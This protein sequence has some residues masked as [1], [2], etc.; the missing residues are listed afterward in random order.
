[1][2]AAASYPAAIVATARRVAL[3][4]TG[5]DSDAVVIEVLARMVAVAT[6]GASAGFLRLPPAAPVAVNPRRPRS[7]EE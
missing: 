6:R 2:T 1:M 4:E 3:E 5:E 7:L